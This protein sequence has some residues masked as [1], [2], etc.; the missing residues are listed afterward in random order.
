MQNA[1][2]PERTSVHVVCQ[3]RD[4]TTMTSGWSPTAFTG[5]GGAEQLGRLEEGLDLRGRLLLRGVKR[6]LV[7]VHPDHRDLRLQARLDVVVVAGRDVDPALLGA[8]PALGLLEV[9]GV[10]LVGP[11]LLRGHDEVEVDLE[12][13]ARL[14][15]EL[16]VD[17]RDQADLE[18][19]REAVE[20]RVGL[21]ERRPA[22][23]RRRE[24][25]RARR[26]ERPA[27]LLGDLDGG[28]AQ[29]L[30]VELVGPALDLLLGLEEEREQLGTRQRVAVL[31][32]FLGERV[33]DTRLPIDEGAVDVEGD[34]GDFLR[35]RH[36]RRSIVTARAEIRRYERFCAMKSTAQDAADATAPAA[37]APPAPAA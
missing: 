34:V 3:K 15:E 8:D 6:L 4:V 19:L 10:R 36:R 11:D 20:L 18:L 12:V 7:A 5:L 23:D 13:P 9:R 31:V 21:L 35:E 32:G 24:E 25:P 29:D 30:G 17:V 33:V 16:V 14:A 1:S 26:L 2:V 37:I 27:E 28:A 22:H